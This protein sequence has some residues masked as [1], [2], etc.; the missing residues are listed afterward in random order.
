MTPGVTA[1]GPCGAPLGA[2]GPLWTP[3]DPLW[4]PVKPL[5]RGLW[6]T[7]GHLKRWPYGYMYT[8]MHVYNYTYITESA[9]ALSHNLYHLK[10]KQLK[11]NRIGII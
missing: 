6:V 2:C 11:S 7:V 3:V 8:F 9:E 1:V 10:A 5:Q 4:A